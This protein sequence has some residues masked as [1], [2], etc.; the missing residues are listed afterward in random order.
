MMKI[1]EEC[2]CYSGSFGHYVSKDFATPF[3]IPG[4]RTK[5]DNP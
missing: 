2:T 3:D 5:K 1:L 4:Q